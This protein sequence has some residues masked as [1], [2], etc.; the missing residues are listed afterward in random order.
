[1]WLLLLVQ[2]RWLFDASR[3]RRSRATALTPEERAWQAFLRR[4][5]Y[6]VIPGY[7]PVD[8]CESARI[9]LQAA[10]ADPHKT[11]RHEEDL[12]VFG[13]ERLS[14]RAAQFGSDSRLLRAATE[15]ARSDEALVFCMA[16]CVRH[17]D[18]VAL[19]SGGE[20]H[21][22]GYRRQMKALLYL[23]DVDPADGPFSVV[24]RSH[25]A[26]QILRDSLVLGAAIRRRLIDGLM[27]TRLKDAGTRLGQRT[28]G[29]TKLLTGS[30]GTLILFDTSTIHTGTPPLSG[31]KERL[32]LTNYYVD[33]KSLPETLAYYRTAVTLN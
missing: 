32:A 1:M 31:G 33:A 13:I 2:Q 11:S 4:F 23:T 7:K 25:R 22:D 5:G 16:N 15:Y 30:A 14:L 24:E 3:R 12:R 20:W 18:G 28:P 27:G 21:R 29:R 17:R 8:W 19:G 9:E 6:V 26:G 10:L